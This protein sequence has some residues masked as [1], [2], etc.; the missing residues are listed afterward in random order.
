MTPARPI[1][2]LRQYVCTYWAEGLPYGIIVYATGPDQIL[3]SLTVEG[4]L[5]CEIDDEE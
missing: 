2:P 5:I 4:E 3:P 1:G